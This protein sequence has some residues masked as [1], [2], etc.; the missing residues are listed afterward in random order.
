MMSGGD[1]NGENVKRGD[2]TLKCTVQSAAI[3]CGTSPLLELASQMV[4]CVAGVVRSTS[5]EIHV[6]AVRRMLHIAQEE[7]QLLTQWR[8]ASLERGK[9]GG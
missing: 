7:E 2:N 5:T 1:Q 4:L 6:N 9:E 3:P 8:E